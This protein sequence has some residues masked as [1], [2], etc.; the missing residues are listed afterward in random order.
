MTTR[1]Q[2]QRRGLRRV[3]LRATASRWPGGGHRRRHLLRQ[4]GGP[5]RPPRGRFVLE[6]GAD[7]LLDTFSDV[8]TKVGTNA[9]GLF[10]LCSGGSPMPSG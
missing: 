10:S 5:D 6:P 8:R 2:T 1:N 7:D 3:D 4:A 9:D